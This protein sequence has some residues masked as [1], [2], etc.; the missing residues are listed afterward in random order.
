MDLVRAE[1]E[2]FKQEMIDKAKHAGV[3]V[4]LLVAAATLLFLM[5]AVFIAAAILGLATVLPA[6]AA[7][8][9]VGGILLVIAAILIAV[10]VAQLK[11]GNPTPTQTIESVQKD[12]N[13]I[14][15]TGKRE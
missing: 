1:I 13:T 2:Q 6:W 12:V 8:L 11:K 3:G 9:I 4:G 10:G 15:G 7:A 14:T 5:L